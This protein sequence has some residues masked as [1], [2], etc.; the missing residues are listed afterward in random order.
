MDKKSCN[1]DGKKTPTPNKG[2]QPIVPPHRINRQRDLQQQQQQR[3]Q[4]QQQRQPTRNRSLAETV[5]DRVRQQQQQPN[6]PL[7]IAQEMVNRLQQQ[8]E[9][10][11]TGLTAERIEMFEHFNAD[12]LLVG[13]KCIVCLDELQIGVQMVRLGCHVDHYLCK[14]CTDTWFKDNNTCPSCRNVFK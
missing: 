2:V 3:Q 7:R 8:Q 5:S 9:Q 11:Q 13:E 12:E 6:L 10:Q 4:Q 14:K 1:S